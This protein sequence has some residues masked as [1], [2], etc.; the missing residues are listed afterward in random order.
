VEYLEQHRGDPK[1]DVK[2]EVLAA[3]KILGGGTSEAPGR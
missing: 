1:E 3:L 2:T